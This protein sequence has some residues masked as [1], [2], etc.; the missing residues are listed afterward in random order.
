VPTES[1]RAYRVSAAQVIRLGARQPVLGADGGPID[2]S[3][4]TILCG[5]AFL[6]PEPGAIATH[7]AAPGIH[8]IRIA[9]REAVLVRL[10]EPDPAR[11]RAIADAIP[12]PCVAAH[13]IDE[14]RAVER[15]LNAH[16]EIE[17]SIAQMLSGVK[18]IDALGLAVNRT[19]SILFD[20]EQAGIYFREPTSSELRLVGASGMEDWERE[21]AE[22]TAW[23]RH[24]G[25]V[26]RTGRMVVVDDVRKDPRSGTDYSARRI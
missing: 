25:R 14:L 11:I 2:P 16:R 24:P 23:D 8:A 21:E 20:F 7:D 22:R 17:R 4:A 13:R 6:P 3:T 9:P 5:D 15:R 19:A 18:D 1:T 12:A 26:L 10:T